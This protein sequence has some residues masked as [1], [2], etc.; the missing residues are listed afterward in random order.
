MKEKYV[1]YSESEHDMVWLETKRLQDENE[2]LRDIVV[3]LLW[4]K[5]PEKPRCVD[6]VSKYEM[7]LGMYRINRD[8]QIR[9]K[10][11]EFRNIIG[12]APLP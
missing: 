5:A 11:E 1:L 3:E 10:L 9:L 4:I 6:S 12:I 2:E 7:E 8:Y